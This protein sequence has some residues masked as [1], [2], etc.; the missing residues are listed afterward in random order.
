MMVLFVNQQDIEQFLIKV[1]G[2]LDPSESAAS[3]NN[4]FSCHGRKSS[5]SDQITNYKTNS[6]IPE[7]DQIIYFDFKGPTLQHFW[8]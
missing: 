5:G 3:N 6:Y 7:C 2:E 4:F 8:E 1:S